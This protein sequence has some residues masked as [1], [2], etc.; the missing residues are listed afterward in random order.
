MSKIKNIVREITPKAIWNF[1]L[2]IKRVVHLN[3]SIG[4]KKI[5][6]VKNHD[7]VI[8]LGNGPSLK[9]DLEELAMKSNSY[10]FVCVNNFSSST[11]YEIFKPEIYIFLDPLFFT[12]KAHADWITQRENTFKII[13]E[14]T[15]WPMK[16]ILPRQA[17]KK[18]LE[19]IIKNCNIEIIKINVG[20]SDNLR[21]YNSGYFGP[22]QVNVLIYAIYLSIWARYKHIEIY[23]AD[24]S[25]HK[26]MD[27]D[28]NDNSLVMT[29]KHFNSENTVEKF[30][31]GPEKSVSVTMSKQ[32][33]NMSAAFKAHEILN[34]YAI[35]KETKIINI[36]GYSM[37]DAYERPF[38]DK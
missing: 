27:V 16:I 23:G 3:G 38:Y 13:N 36:S 33:E 34:R 32:M 22:S 20:E 2:L 30:M 9:K 31:Q 37:I 29:F 6:F 14:K 11:Y 25:M 21:L 4:L 7:N 1:L 12:E 26:N 18:V 15:T 8:V 28:Q 17:N 24:M 35:Q 5:D 10:D 19:R